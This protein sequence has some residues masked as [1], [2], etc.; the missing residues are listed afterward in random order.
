MVKKNIANRSTRNRTQ[1]TL[2]I[3]SAITLVVLC[4]L[5]GFSYSDYLSKEYIQSGMLVLLLLFL[6]MNFYILRLYTS[7]KIIDKSAHQ[8]SLGKLNIDDIS[9]DKTKGLETLS[10]TFNDMKRNLL[11]FVESTKSNVIVLSDAVDKV[12]KSLEMSYKGNEHI[13]SNMNIVAEKAHDQLIIAKDTLDGIQEVAHH[14]NSITASLARIEGFMNDTVHITNLG[15]NHLTEYNYQIDIISSNLTQTSNFIH[16]LNE[17]L[18]QINQVNGLI[19]NITEQL[20]LLSLNSTVEAA[21]AGDAGK[22]F[23]VVAQEMNKLSFATRNSIGQISGLLANI[24][25]SNEEVSASIQNCLDNFNNSKNIFSSVKNSLYTINE[26]ANI[27]NQD[28]KKVYEEARLIDHN[29]KGI[30]EKG[31]LLHES[32]NEISS[33]TQEVAAVTQEELAENEE[34]NHQALS[35]SHMLSGIETLLTRYKTSVTPTDR[36]PNKRIRIAMISPLDSPFWQGVR[37]G[38]LYAKNELK[39]R[40]VD[41]DYIGFESDFHQFNSIIREKIDQHYDGIILP[42]F[43]AQVE[44]YVALAYRNNIPVI[45]FNCDFKEGTRRLTYLGPDVKGASTHAGELVVKALNSTGEFAII[46]NG[47]DNQ[48]NVFRSNALLSVT[49]KKRKIRLI[50]EI[51]CGVRNEDVYGKVKDALIKH[52]N[53]KIIVIMSGGALGAAKAIKELHKEH[54]VKLLCFDYDSDVISLIKE[55]IVYAAIGQ[56]PF[57]QGHDPIITMYNYLVTKEKPASIHYTRME[58]LDNQS[59]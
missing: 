8:L 24:L 39:G 10:I 18:K 51:S 30:R 47:V 40:N 53:L 46:H 28:M 14:T 16:T 29:T 22:G 27:L 19:M 12:S 58:V 45:A 31:Y 4:L 13:A 43:F 35:L 17:H 21:R 44:D 57:S 9:S 25:S 1:L 52:P 33:I 32:S 41:I 42:G 6:V 38:V 3:F 50:E 15:Q 48:F 49:S 2:L 5:H 20:K 36:L 37:Q 55:G 56:D 11:S 7:I 54:S 59:I 23:A 34:V 26:N